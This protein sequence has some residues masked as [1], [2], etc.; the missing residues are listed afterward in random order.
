MGPGRLKKTGPLAKDRLSAKKAFIITDKGVRA[1]PFFEGLFSSLKSAGI[2]ADFF[3]DISPDPNEAE[4]VAACGAAKRFCADCIIGIG[5]GSPLDAAKAVAILAK[6]SKPISDL[7]GYSKVTEGRLPLLLIPT[8]AGT[9]S[10]GSAFAVITRPNGEKISITDMASVPDIALLDPELI[11]SLPLH[12]TAA[13]GIDALVHAIEAYSSKGNK[14]QETDAFAVEGLRLL[15]GAVPASLENPGDIK[16]REAALYGSYLAGRAI[17]LAPVGGVH[18]L[19]YP[20]GGLFHIH[21]G[22]SNS[23]LLGPVFRFNLKAAAPLYAELAEAAFPA[24]KGSAEAKALAFL[25]A[26]EHIASMA[27]LPTRLSQI[28][29]GEKDIPALVSEAM[30]LERLLVNNPVPINSGVC[31]DIYSQIL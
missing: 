7:Y 1:L 6:S 29:I 11:T 3:E 24:P 14:N 23:I 9:G 26:C 25:G 30:K 28:G 31:R 8:T 2:E 22:L 4:I 5:G 21:H 18:A 13:T 16:A 15:M 17:T 20:L 10:E 27:N 12:L 19:A